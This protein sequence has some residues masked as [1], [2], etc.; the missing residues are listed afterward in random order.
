MLLSRRLMSFAAV[1]ATLAAFG[2]TPVA[3]SGASGGE[4]PSANAYENAKV[5]PGKPYS[6]GDGRKN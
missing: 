2:A 5:L 3:A 4:V 1:A 6:A